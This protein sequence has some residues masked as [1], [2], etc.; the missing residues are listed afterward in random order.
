MS[1]TVSCN[2]YDGNTRCTGKTVKFRHIMNNHVT[3]CC[4][5]TSTDRFDSNI[6]KCRNKTE[7]VP[8]K[9]YFKV[10]AFKTLKNKNKLWYEILLT[11]D[12]I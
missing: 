2:S 6:F 1:F 10:Y 11:K 8:K 9:P 4:C 7:H 12:G 5:Q 3:M